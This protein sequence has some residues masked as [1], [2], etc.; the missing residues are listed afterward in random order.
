MSLSFVMVTALQFSGGKSLT[1]IH[2][3]TILTHAV[4][5]RTVKVIWASSSFFSLL[6]CR[7]YLITIIAGGVH[8][9]R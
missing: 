1:K 9:V 2:S 7:L 5:D 3:D 8:R 6:F 4:T